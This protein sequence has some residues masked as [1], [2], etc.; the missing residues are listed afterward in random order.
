MEKENGMLIPLEFKEEMVENLIPTA[1]TA[2]EKGR[3]RKRRKYIDG[4]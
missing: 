1:N 2:K 4:N 3:V